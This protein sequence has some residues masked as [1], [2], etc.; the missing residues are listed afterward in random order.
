MF[1]NNDIQKL[2][3]EIVEFKNEILT[4]QDEIL[5]KLNILLDEKTIGDEQDKRQKKVLEIHNSALKKNKI[6]SKEEALQI[7][8]LQVF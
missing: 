7:D 8:K 1:E 6:L 4:G 5:E 2:S 3:D